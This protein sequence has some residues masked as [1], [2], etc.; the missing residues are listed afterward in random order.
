MQLLCQSPFSWFRRQMF[1]PVSINHFSIQQFRHV[2]SCLSESLGSKVTFLG[3]LFD[4]FMCLPLIFFILQKIKFD[5]IFELFSFNMEHLSCSRYSSTLSY[6]ITRFCFSK[7][8]KCNVIQKS[9][10]NLSFDSQY[11]S[12]FTPDFSP[13]SYLL[14]SMC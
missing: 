2:R 3:I 12:V 5:W 8:W 1:S 7:Q 11:F 6:S 4:L 10:Q 9:K 13:S 14:K